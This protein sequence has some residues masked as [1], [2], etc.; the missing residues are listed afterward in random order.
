MKTDTATPA[1][2]AGQEDST[3]GK[4]RVKALL[5]EPL[6]LAGLCRPRGVTQDTHRA[7]LA[8]LAER[9]SYMTPDNLG[10]LRDV[11]QIHAASPGGGGAWPS[12][13]VVEAWAQGLQPRPPRES[14]IIRSWLASV[15]G[16]PALAAG[17][18][19]QL[20]RFLRRRMLPPSDY[21]KRMIREQAERD[22]R[23]AAV[24]DERVRNG[25]ARGDERDWLEA[26]AR[27]DATVREIIAE[28]EA[29]R[30]ARAR[31]A[32]RQAAQGSDGE[33]A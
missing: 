4:A 26:Y 20:F 30:V 19:V 15:E 16:P 22:R 10:T 28:G 31:E 24:C 9:L 23:H 7:R 6:D 11:I 5:I 29:R 32:A 17:H 21:D 2:Q 1:T 8:Q 12:P 13:V 33:A 25:T 3:S 14:D 27:D 18:H